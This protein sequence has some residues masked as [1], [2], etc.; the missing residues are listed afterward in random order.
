MISFTELFYLI[1]E[2]YMMLYQKLY[3][4]NSTGWNMKSQHEGLESHYR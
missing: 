2:Q 3:L 4:L 1:N